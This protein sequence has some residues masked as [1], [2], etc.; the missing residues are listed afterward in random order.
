MHCTAV[1][2][3]AS[4]S[5]HF[6]SRSQKQIANLNFITLVSKMQSNYVHRKNSKIDFQLLSSDGRFSN[7]TK[8]SVN[9]LC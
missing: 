8:N 7:E 3:A 4:T 9:I 5:H 1:A 2:A 6:S